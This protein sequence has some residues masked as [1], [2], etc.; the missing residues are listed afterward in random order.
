MPIRLARLF[1]TLLILS[2][3]SYA[4]GADRMSLVQNEQSLPVDILNHKNNIL[5]GGLLVS[6]SH[7]LCNAGLLITMFGFLKNIHAFFAGCYIVLG[8]FATLLL[9][10]GG[11]FL[12]LPIVASE[13]VV[14]FTDATVL[15][16][17]LILQLCSAANFY[18]YQCGMILWGL[19]GTVLCVLLIQSAC[20]PVWLLIFG[21]TGYVVFITGC[22]LELFGYQYG[23][24]LSV[25]GGLFEI[26]FSIRMIVKGLA[27]SSKIKNGLLS[28]FG[29]AF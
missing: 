25:P 6:V 29:V 7:T 23:V 9:A 17:Q 16:F 26:I 27:P 2:F 11:I 10:L 13:N 21:I 8:M 15:Q 12:Q 5:S 4:I 22:L 18:M 3:L 1:G 19:G 28:V 20:A 24:L 14:A